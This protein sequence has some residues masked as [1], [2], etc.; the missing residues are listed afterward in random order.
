MKPH[1]PDKDIIHSGSLEITLDGDSDNYND[2]HLRMTL[3]GIDIKDDGECVGAIRFAFS[4]GV[5]IVVGARHWYV[6]PEALFNL[7]K[8]ADDQYLASRE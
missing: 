7:A 1:F 4:G 5:Q 6:S 2:E 3:H 8:D